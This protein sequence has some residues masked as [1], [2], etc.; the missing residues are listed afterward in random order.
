MAQVQIKCPNSGLWAS[1]G[2]SAEPEQWDELEIRSR[3]SVCGVCGEMHTWAK[4]D[5][6]LVDW[7][8]A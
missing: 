3:T 2:L 1:I 8:W 5:A 7:A 6:R 4:G